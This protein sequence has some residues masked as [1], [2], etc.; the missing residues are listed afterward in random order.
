MLPHKSKYVQGVP[1]E[2]ELRLKVSEQD[3]DRIA[4]NV[5]DCTVAK[6]HISVSGDRFKRV[7]LNNPKPTGKFRTHT[8]YKYAHGPVM[9]KKKIVKT[10]Y[11][12]TLSTEVTTKTKLGNPTY[13]RIIQRKHML[14]SKKHKVS[15]DL[16]KEINA[17]PGQFYVDDG[18]LYISDFA[19]TSFEVEVEI[20]STTG[21]PPSVSALDAF[22]DALDEVYIAYR[23]I[24]L[25][26]YVDIFSK[27]TTM[28]TGSTRIKVD[29]PIEA[30]RE[31]L[32]GIASRAGHL[33]HKADGIRALIY[34]D[35]DGTF[36]IN[37]TSEPHVA[38]ISS[39]VPFNIT[40]LIDAELHIDRILA[41][42]TLFYDGKD[43]RSQP[44]TQRRSY[45][46]PVDLTLYTVELKPSYAYDGNFD[47]AIDALFDAVP[48]FSTDGYIATPEHT[49]T[50][51][52][53]KPKNMLTVDLLLR[54]DPFEAYVEVPTHGPNVL[55]RVLLDIQEPDLYSDGDIVEFSFDGTVFE[56]I[57]SRP[58]KTR[59]NYINA[60]LDVI[61]LVQRPVDITTHQQQKPLG[62][63]RTV[64]SEGHYFAPR[65]QDTVVIVGLNQPVDFTTLS[66]KVHSVVDVGQLELHRVNLGH[67]NYLKLPEKFEQKDAVWQ[68]V[69]YVDTMPEGFIFDTYID[70]DGNLH[71]ADDERTLFTVKDGSVM[72]KEYNSCT[73][74]DFVDELSFNDDI[75]LKYILQGANPDYAYYHHLANAFEV[76]VYMF[77]PAYHITIG[78]DSDVLIKSGMVLC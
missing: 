66:P 29:K 33:S 6:T 39:E 24:A 78:E 17:S 19:P 74:D 67:V 18:I 46:R 36:L 13:V 10:K 54:N 25:D 35:P 42:D 37:P 71:T 45:I 58:D 11:G 31:D 64:L 56:P 68:K 28:L 77:L 4:A 38:L 34:F 61:S 21:R 2:L 30:R 62:H 15:I 44:Y 14:I 52:K 22:V 51:Y 63:G 12:L 60:F 65:S 3:Y 43:V 32:P 23:G 20:V 5:A 41:F 53:V 1:N 69:N 76:N 72:L 70:S 16:S 75:K 8:M 57:R 55:S 26:T 40:M 48:T 9:S 7:K 49:G 47:E 73:L 50:T 59:P 27:V